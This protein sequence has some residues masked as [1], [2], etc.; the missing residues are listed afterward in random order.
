MGTTEDTK[1]LTPAQKHARKIKEEKEAARELLRQERER[2]EGPKQVVPLNLFFAVLAKLNDW[3]H[4]PEFHLHIL[5]FLEKSDEW[6]NNTAVLQ[7]YRNSA[8]STIAAAYIV[9]LLVNDPTL[10]I[11]IQ[12][13]DDNTA[14]KMV[15]DCKRII[16]I[17]PMAQHLRGKDSTWTA[18][19]IVVKGSSSG[20]NS[21]IEARGIFSNVTGSRADFIIFDDTE[22]PRNAGSA[23]LRERLRARIAESHHLLNPGGKKLFIGTPHNEVSIYPE[24]VDKGATSLVI[25]MLTNI[26]GEFPNMGGNI[27]WHERW[28]IAEVLAKQ[29]AC[30]SRSEFYSQYLLIPAA[31]ADS[32]LDPA[33]LVV[34][35]DEV[36]TIT[37]NKSTLL[38]IGENRMRAVCAFW[39]VATNS[40]RGD[41]SVLA[42]VYLS[43]DGKLYIHRVIELKGEIE[44]Q[45]RQVKQ[46]AIEFK[47]SRICIETNGVGAFAPAMMLK[48]VRGLGIAIEGIHS[49]QKKS[50]K[51]IEAFEIPM[52]ARFLYVHSS[53]MSTKFMTQL[54]DFNPSR[55][56]KHDDFI[57]A[58][59][60]AIKQLPVTIGAGQ[61]NSL[62]GFKT[63][64]PMGESIEIERVLA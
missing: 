32:I 1:P 49:T 20:R 38:R 46:V 42:I 59:A 36:E 47:L 30:K 10:L 6:N 23:E 62:D 43:Y 50:E 28:D 16:N 60:S 52:S 56:D 24:L 25:P 11:L 61:I 4:I 44:Q 57:D 12:S 13:A 2:L 41:A 19:K 21:S 55:M 45:C 8:K 17:H 39:D 3:D 33:D 35:E 53:V 37:A 48:E 22:V 14:M 34:Y 40:K 51:I 5:E 9:W 58:P 26:E 15:E 63:W 54:R 27:T 64:R 7:A 31:L 29:M 18:K